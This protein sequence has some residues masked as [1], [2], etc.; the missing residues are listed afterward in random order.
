LLSFTDVDAFFKHG[1]KFVEVF[2]DVAK[3]QN[4]LLFEGVII[5]DGVFI[6]VLDQ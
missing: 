3:R 4:E 1:F 6:K 2:K 5:I